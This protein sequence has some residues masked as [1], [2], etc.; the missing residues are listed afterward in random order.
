MM[1]KFRDYKPV[2]IVW[3]LELLAC[4]CLF[5]LKRLRCYVWRREVGTNRCVNKAIATPVMINMTVA[6]PAS[7]KTSLVYINL[8]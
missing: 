5:W 3:W 4:G 1:E 6:N 8:S 2:Y 7:L